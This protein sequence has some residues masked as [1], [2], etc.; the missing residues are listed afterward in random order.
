[1]VYLRRS[2]MFIFNWSGF[3]RLCSATN[4]SWKPMVGRIARLAAIASKS[5]A[6]S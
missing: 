2:T 6:L 1:M 5:L 4:L 3:G